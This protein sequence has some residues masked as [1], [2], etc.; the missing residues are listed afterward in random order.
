TGAPCRCSPWAWRS[1][2]RSRPAAHVSPG[3]ARWLRPGRPDTRAHRAH[4]S[5][6]KSSAAL[7]LH[8]GGPPWRSGRARA[9]LRLASESPNSHTL[10]RVEPQLIVRG[11]PKGLI[12]RIDITND[13]IAAELVG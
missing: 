13:L 8:D 4:G 12:E 7:P 5:H 3:R 10:I 2:R 11:N 6:R 1:G 9:C